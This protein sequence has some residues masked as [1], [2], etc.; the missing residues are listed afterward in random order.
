MGLTKLLQQTPYVPCSMQ[1]L[2]LPH[3]NSIRPPSVGTSPNSHFRSGRKVMYMKARHTMHMKALAYIDIFACILPPSFPP[4]PPQQ[5]SQPPAYMGGREQ[6]RGTLT[7]YFGTH[8]NSRHI[9]H[10]GREGRQER[11]GKSAML[12]LFFRKSGKEFVHRDSDMETPWG[13]QN[14]SAFGIWEKST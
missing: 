11:R 13:L 1:P 2:L 9:C 12:L 6:E 8:Y 5:H 14:L 3:L 4:P 7:N 10:G